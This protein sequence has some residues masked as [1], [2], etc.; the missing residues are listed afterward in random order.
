[1]KKF[2][3]LI[4]SLVITL[5]LFSQQSG[6]DTKGAKATAHT[7]T[8]DEV[9]NALFK[10]DGLYRD[11]KPSDELV[12]LRSRNT[13]HFLNPDGSVTEIVG[14]GD[15]HYFEDGEWKEI[16]THIFQNKTGEYAD[17]QFA[18]VYNGHKNFFPEQPGMAIVTKLRNDVYQDWE[19]PAMVW[20]DANA[21]VIAEYQVNDL[22]TGVPV[23]DSI[24]YADIFPHTDAVILNSVT[25]KKLSY[26]LRDSSLLADK[27][28]GAVYLA[29]RETIHTNSSWKLSGTASNEKI[30]ASLASGQLL[31][32]MMFTDGTGQQ[33][34]EIQTPLYFQKDKA[35]A[36]GEAWNPDP[37]RFYNGS[38]LVKESNAGYETYTLVP[39]QWLADS[40]RTFPVV[41]DPVTN[42][43]PGYTWPTYTV[44]RSNNS[45]GWICSPGTYA[46]RTYQYDIS[47]GWIDDTWPTNN[48]FLYGYSTFDITA[49]Q[50]I[51]CITSVQYN[52][53]HY[54]SRSCG[55]DVT[56]KFGRVTGNYNLAEEPSCTI[57]GDAIRNNNSYYNGTGKNGNGWQSYTGGV[58]DFVAALPGNQITLG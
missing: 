10:V 51:A 34:V 11:Y 53:Y 8:P 13:K 27:P 31:Q 42:Y 35:L 30:F 1:M 40:S 26:F 17:H 14:A 43:Y 23:K 47:Y 25:S 41:I 6:I 19:H 12:E 22:A 3:T 24:R 46:G 18:A 2:F 39:V 5:P 9:I 57:T 28:A 4:F 32:N 58:A 7:K 55:T 56:L 16:L 15:L 44:Y 54:A 50:D 49:L 33:E 38:Y 37:A 36:P 20:L 29:F 48:P 21:N 45:G 52:W